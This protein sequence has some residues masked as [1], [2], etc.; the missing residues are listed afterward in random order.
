MART[1]VTGLNSH[2]VERTDAANED[3]KRAAPIGTTCLPFAC[4]QEW[5]HLGKP[6]FRGEN[7]EAERG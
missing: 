5:D 3:K 2:L 1:L 6:P 4:L 7:T